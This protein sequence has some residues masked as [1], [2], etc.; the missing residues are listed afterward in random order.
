ME[1]TK[2]D[3]ALSSTFICPVFRAGK[4]YYYHPGL[5]CSKG[6]YHYPLEAIQLE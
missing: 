5:G 2:E 6:G 1:S 3:F 4:E